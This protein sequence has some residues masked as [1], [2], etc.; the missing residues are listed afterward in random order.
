MILPNGQKAMPFNREIFDPPSPVATIAAAAPGAKVTYS[1]AADPAAAAAAAAQAD[2]VIVFAEQW[3]TEGA[4]VHSLALS[5][6]QDALIAAVAAAN[7]HTIVVLE[8]GG[9]VLMPWLDKVPAVLEAW[10]SG[11]GGAAALTRILFG[12]VNPSGRLPITFPASEDQMPS[13]EHSYGPTIGYPEGADVGYRWY[14]T[15]KLAPLFPFGFGLSYTSFGYSNFAASGGDGAGASVTVAN[16]G[17][18]AGSEVVQL[19][20]APPGGTARLVA[21]QKVRLAPGESKTVN[22]A[23]EPRLLAQYDTA[24]GQW[25]IDAGSYELSIRASATDVKAASQVAVNARTIKP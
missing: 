2:L 12:A 10:Y 17:T 22:L 8:T 4:D 11:S 1:D 16:T 19:Y 23:A 15:K 5:G 25:R 24:L 20:A 9:P 14:E 3:M 6:Q 18:R 13:P 21:F 7:P